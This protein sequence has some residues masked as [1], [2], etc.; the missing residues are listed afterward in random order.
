MG[1]WRMSSVAGI[2]PALV[3]R[4]SEPAIATY[5]NAVMGVY[6]PKTCVTLLAASLDLVIVFFAFSHSEEEATFS[7]RQGEVALPASALM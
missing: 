4:D 2:V 1:Y 5:V 7:C 6:D 3:L